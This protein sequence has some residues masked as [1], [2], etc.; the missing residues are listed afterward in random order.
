MTES[1]IKPLKPIT[2]RD[3]YWLPLEGWAL[4]TRCGHMVANKEATAIQRR[5]ASLGLVGG[6]TVISAW[7]VFPA[8]IL[9]GAA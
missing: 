8:M 7:I 2:L 5:D 4:L 6:Y 1:P 9:A 3:C